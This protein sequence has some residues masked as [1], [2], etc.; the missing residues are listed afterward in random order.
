MHLLVARKNDCS[1]SNI[2]QNRVFQDLLPRPP[3]VVWN[4]L[5]KD[6]IGFIYFLNILPLSYNVSACKDKIKLGVLLDM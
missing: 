3:L 5:Y 2:P 1:G 4:D 6:H